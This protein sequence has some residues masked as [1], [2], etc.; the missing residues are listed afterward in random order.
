MVVEEIAVRT[1]EGCSS[2]LAFTNVISKTAARRILVRITIGSGGELAPVEPPEK[3][4]WNDDERAADEPADREAGGESPIPGIMPDGGDD[5]VDE[6][7]GKHE[8]PGEIQELVGAQTR[9][10]ATR[11]DEKSDQRQQL[12]RK[13]DG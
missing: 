8:L 1:R 11:P 4:V 10:G 9:K 5:E 7:H 3:Q 13:P 2:A 6:G 12:E